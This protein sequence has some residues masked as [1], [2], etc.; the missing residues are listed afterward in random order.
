[1]VGGNEMNMQTD[2][3]K[4]HS[5]KK[6]IGLDDKIYYAVT[7][8]IMILLTLIV[9]YPLIYVVSASFSSPSAVSSGKVFLF[10]VEFSL[11][12][13]L[14]VFKNPSILIG[15]RNSFLYTIFGTLI[16]VCVTMIAAYPLSR[17]DLPNRGFFTFLFTFTM[18][19]S[20]GMIPNYILLKN[21]HMINTPWA[22]LLPGALSI[23][24]MIIARTFIQSN[25]PGELFDA[26][27]IDGC[28]DFNY[29]TKIILPLSKSVLAVITLYYAVG[30]WNS[31]FNAFL[32][33]NEKNLFPLQIFLRDILIANAVDANMTLDPELMEAKQGLAS[34]LKYSL[35]IVSSAP[36][37]MLYPFVQK[38]FVKGVM[39]GSVKG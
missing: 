6:A 17:R 19:F 18:I 2:I 5:N 24:N 15:Y 14:A 37:L 20:G 30:H 27:R 10:P 26:S 34:L 13:Y 28:N 22:M 25:I 16:N 8:T 33:L 3:K 29:F 39:I 4:K 32:Y 38:H 12:G 1:M 9:L 7:N 23:Y 36:V 21:L 31:Y 11:E 35:I